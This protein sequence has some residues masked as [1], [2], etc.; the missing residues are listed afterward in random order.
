MSAQ[1]DGSTGAGDARF[2]VY[3]NIR[4]DDARFQGRGQSQNGAGGVAARVSNQTGGGN[5][6]A[7][8]FR[9]AE[10]SFLE[11]FR[12]GMSK[13]VP[14]RIIGGVFQPEISADIDNL[15]ALFEQRDNLFGA[16]LMRQGRESH[17]DI[18]QL[19]R[20]C[21]VEVGQMGENGCQ[22]LPGGAPTSDRGYLHIRVAVKQ[23]HQLDS[24][25]TR[26][27]NNACF[28]FSYYRHS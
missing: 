23:P 14:L 24:G 8:Q 4:F 21:Q 27:V 28:G 26:N 12:G 7:I 20:D 2:A 11:Q 15:N 25:I 22:L 1:A 6:R 3:D 17:I 13:L 10:N 9:K 18:A 19:S 5:L 16:L